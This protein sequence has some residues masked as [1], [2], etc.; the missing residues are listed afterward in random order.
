MKLVTQLCTMYDSRI[1]DF[2]L[3]QKHFGVGCTGWFVSAITAVKITRDGFSFCGSELYV[4][5]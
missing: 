1:L 2:E 4:V 5:R 3:Y